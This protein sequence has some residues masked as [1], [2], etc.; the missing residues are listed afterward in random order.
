MLVTER[1][2]TQPNAVVGRWS[3][4]VRGMD[5]E[6][7]PQVTR[8]KSD[9][10]RRKRILCIV[11]PSGCEGLIDPPVGDLLA[12]LDPLRLARG[13]GYPSGGIA[14]R[15]A[16]AVSRPLPSLRPDSQ[17]NMAAGGPVTS[18]GGLVPMCSMP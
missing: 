1:S 4:D 16:L 7:F 6:P 13:A 18:T 17:A 11:D 15:A 5:L 12:A 3:R 8:R 10:R 2:Q 9:G 14:G